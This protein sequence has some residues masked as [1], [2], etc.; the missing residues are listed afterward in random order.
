MAAPEDGGQTSAERDLLERVATRDNRL[1]GIGLDSPARFINREMSWLAFN[2]R[3]LDEAFNAR[4]PLLERLRFLSISASNLDEFFMVRVA[5]LRGQVSHHVSELSQEG[6]SAQE[7]LDLLNVDAQALMQRQQECWRTLLPL[8][9][10]AGVEVLDAD[11]LTDDESAWIEQ[12]FLANIFPVLTPIAVDPAHPFP[13]IQNL[14]LVVSL[15]LRRRDGTPLT[16]LIQ[17]PNK[18]ARF[19]RLPSFEAPGDS[20]RRARFISLEKIIVRFYQHLFPG[21]TLE[22]HGEF[23]VVRDSDIEIEEEAEDLVRLFETLLKRR[24]RGDVIR[25][26]INASM[27]E[28]MRQ[29]VI[30]RINASPQDVFIVDGVLGLAQTSQLIPSDRPDIQF[31]AYEPRFPERIREHGGDCFSAIRDKDFIVHHPYESFDV[32]V[33]FLKQAAND[34]NV[35]AIKQTLYRTSKD[36]P[37]VSALIEAAENGKNVTALVEL[38]ARFDEEANINWARALERAG[39]NVVYG[40]VELKTHAKLSLVARKEGEI[41]RTYAHVGT[42]NYHAFTARV[43]TDLSLFT[44]DPAIGRDATRVFNYITGYAKPQSFEKFAVANIDMRARLV[45]LIDDEIRH[46]IAGRPASIW[47]KMNSLVDGTDHRQ[48]LR[49][50]YGRRSGRS[51]RSRNMLPAAGR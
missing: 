35:L 44:C 3:V 18:V 49:G 19:V 2:T 25:L 12:E 28:S 24:R 30:E 21:M 4:H 22:A 39:V 42:G 5:G 31:K 33:Q 15:G 8:I 41:V 13:F 36:S 34:P 17:L 37:I 40:F 50:E 38:K 51:C 14:G 9:R 48:A 11:E 7:Q 47:G 29:L 46:A 6:L 1:I 10:D 20:R 43:Y 23:R 16:I 32:V 26:K 45:R 27:P